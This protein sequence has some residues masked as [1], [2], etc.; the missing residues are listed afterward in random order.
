M[1]SSAVQLPTA[2]PRRHLSDR[3]AKTVHK[4]TEAAVVE[5]IETGYPALTVRNVAKR[6]GVAPA[7]AYTYFASK[8]HLVAEV[9]W[10][11][12]DGQEPQA[13][14]GHRSPAE[15][16][17][18]VLL[19][20]ALV[21]ADE[22]ELAAACTVALLADDPE[23]RELRVRIGLEMHRRLGEAVGDDAPPAAIQTL[24]L[25]TTG[26]LLQVGTGHLAYDAVPDLLAEAA[27]L[28]LGGAAR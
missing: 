25:A 4:L 16:A 13:V 7:T 26:A 20:F 21:V 1:S 17:T 15:R 2:A 11:R 19:D 8:E 23:V 9:F 28:V 5:L 3:Q 14:D 12:F 18:D 27:A 10:R 6:A 22:T 24:E